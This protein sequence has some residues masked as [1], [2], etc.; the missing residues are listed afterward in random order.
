MNDKLQNTLDTLAR[1]EAF[2]KAI[3]EAESVEAIQKLFRD[4][5]VDVTEEEIGALLRSA[6]KR[7]E[8]E[9]GELNELSL[10]EVAGGLSFS[11]EKS[12]RLPFQ[13][14]VGPQVC[15]RCGRKYGGAF[16]SCRFQMGNF[17]LK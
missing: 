8:G 3:N 15:S 6:V 16:C 5:G 11:F 9:L 10:E 14:I 12:T 17:Q 4:Q 2:R 1:D 7:G 13:Q